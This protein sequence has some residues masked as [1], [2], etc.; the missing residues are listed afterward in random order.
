MIIAPLRGWK[1]LNM[2]EQPKQ[3][4]ILFRKKSGRGENQ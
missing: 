3:M 1:R 4:K 2:R